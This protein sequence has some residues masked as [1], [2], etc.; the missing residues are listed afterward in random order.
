M[1]RAP[2]EEPQGLVYRTELISA[3]EERELLDELQSPALGPDR[4]ARR[5]G[6]TERQA[7]RA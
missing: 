5:Y 7:F 6:A 1:A 2:S 3:A 4:D